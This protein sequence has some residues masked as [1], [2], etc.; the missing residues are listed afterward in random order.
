MESRL[1]LAGW[2]ELDPGE[3]GG[4]SGWVQRLEWHLCLVTG[5]AGPGRSLEVGG[6]L[7][8]CGQTRLGDLM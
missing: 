5:R 1:D 2:A 4:K 3:G 6:D 8:R 7:G